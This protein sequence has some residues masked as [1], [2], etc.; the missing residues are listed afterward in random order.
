MSNTEKAV[1]DKRRKTRRKFFTEEKFRIV[2]YGLR[3]E[4]SVADLSR[5]EG[6]NS[7]L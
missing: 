2:L 3:G 5:H 4:S 7:N 6:I 1:K